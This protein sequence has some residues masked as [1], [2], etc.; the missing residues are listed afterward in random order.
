MK[1]AAGVVLLLVG[2]VW[3]LQGLGV[4]VSPESFMTG[5][6]TWVVIGAIAV[7]GGVALLWRRGE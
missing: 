6:R 5:S 7:L 3:L 4:I 1:R 2:V